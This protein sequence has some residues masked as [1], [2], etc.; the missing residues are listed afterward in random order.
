MSTIVLR[1]VKGSPLTNAEVDA[2]FTNLNNDKTELGGTYSSG[3]ANGVLFLSASKVLTTGSALTFDGAKLNNTSGSG[4]GIIQSTDSSGSG[5]F[6]RI[7]ADS[8]FGSLINF[9]TGSSLRFATSADNFGSFAEQMRLTSTG[10]GIGTSSPSSKLTVL[11]GDIEIGAT[12]AGNTLL[13]YNGT[14]ANLTVNSSTAS[15][16]LGT[17]STERMRIDSDG[18]VGIGTSSPGGKLHVNGIGFFGNTGASDTQLRM[19]ALDASNTYFQAISGDGTTAKGYVFYN[20]G[21]TGMVLDAPGNLGLGVTPSA[22][23]GTS[24]ALQIKNYLALWQGTNGAT[25]LGFGLYESSANAYTY[26]TTGD[27][28]TMYRQLSGNHYWYTAPSG[29]AGDAVSFTQAMT[30]DAS[31]NLGVGATSPTARLHVLTGSTYAANFYTT[32]TGAGTTRI[33]IG[34]LTTG[35][36]G[37][38][39]SAAIGAEHNHSATAQSSLTFYTHDGTNQLERARIDSS[40]NLLVGTT[41]ASTTH[42]IEKNLSGD[43]ALYLIN[44]NTTDPFGLYIPYSIAPNSTG[45]WF[46]SCQDSSANRMRVHSNGGIANFSGNNINLSDRREKTNFAPAKSYLETIC[47]I[48]VQTFN[49]IDQNMEGDPGLTLG[50]VAQDVQ[51]VAPELVMES[52]W[53][54]QDEPK[55]RLSIYQTD[56]QY[57]LMKCI[58]EQQALIQTLTAR[59]AALES[60]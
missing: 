38:G 44:S 24:K 7:L 25:Q 33:A 58:Q 6:V 43:Q 50:V 12:A 53:G 28:P 60:I 31:G 57:A 37:G 52:N 22:W 5:N 48:P 36:S 29:T 55:Q 26:S 23:G 10:L 4:A 34:G 45:S 2:N 9:T 54:T 19:G 51:A 20:G 8:T 46:I 14:T 32:N 27:A 30:L 59:V 1:S 15:L 17:S 11:N 39:G 35:A 41:A 3:T 49:Y 21:S 42:R 56:L 40:G 47:A 13:S 18:N 16:V